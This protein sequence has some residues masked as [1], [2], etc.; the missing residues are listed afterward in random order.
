MNS[1]RHRFAFRLAALLTTGSMVVSCAPVPGPYQE[2]AN[3]AAYACQQGIPQ[4][5]ADYQA[6]APAAN[7]EAYQSQQN[8]AVGTAVAA[9]LL[10]AVAGAA[11]ASSGDRG[12]RGRGHYRGHGRYYGHR[13]G[14]HRHGWHR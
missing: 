13:G 3:N 7:A 12:Y 4:A 11:I 2:Q 1:Q 8:A 9:G 14:Y 10:G 6:L 5:C